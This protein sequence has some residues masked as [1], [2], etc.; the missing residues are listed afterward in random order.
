MPLPTEDELRALV[1]AEPFDHDSSHADPEV[2]ARKREAFGAAHLAPLQDFRD[3]TLAMMRRAKVADPEPLLP[4]VDPASGGVHARVVLLF[5]SPGAKVVGTGGSGVVSPDNVDP[6]AQ[7][8]WRLCKEAGLPR[9]QQL[10]WNVR[11][12]GTT[13]QLRI[14]EAH[15]LLI[16]WLRTLDG[17][18]RVVLFGAS[19]HAARQIVRAVLPDVDM[20]VCPSPANRA[21]SSQTDFEE[22]ITWAL[23]LRD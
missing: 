14:A 5:E 11:P 3:E 12:W 23:T 16:R 10:H 9:N 2:L 8:M 21:K 18:E 20:V 17:P 1:G 4:Y 19:A 22:Q 7:R 6:A 15:S 13:P